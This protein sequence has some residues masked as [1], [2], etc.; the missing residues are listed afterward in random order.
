MGKLNARRV[1]VSKIEGSR[2][3]ERPRLRWEHNSSFIFKK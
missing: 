1:L 2:S 3:P